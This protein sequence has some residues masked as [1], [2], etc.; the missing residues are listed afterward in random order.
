[1]PQRVPG[2][3]AP[4]FYDELRRQA[5]AGLVPWLDRTLALLPAKEGAIWRKRLDKGSPD[6]EATLLEVLTL[7]L[8]VGQGASLVELHPDFG[9]RAKGKR[10]DFLL[11]HEER[12]LVIESKYVSLQDEKTTERWHRI[13][14]LV[15]GLDKHLGPLDRSYFL[16][17]FDQPSGD[18]QYAR[19]AHELKVA[20]AGNPGQPSYRILD[21]AI[22]LRFQLE[23]TGPA[24][25]GQ[26][27]IW[28]F[29]LGNALG[30]FE[31]L[32]LGQRMHMAI[33]NKLKDY[34]RLHVPM[35][36][37]LGT[38]ETFGPGDDELL[39]T[40]FGAQT[41]TLSSGPGPVQSFNGYNLQGLFGK[42][43][44]RA[45]T[46]LSGVLVVGCWSAHRLFAAFQYK[47]GAQAGIQPWV[48]WVPNPHAEQ[49]IPAL[50][51][52]FPTLKVA[53]QGDEYEF[54]IDPGQ[55]L[56]QVLLS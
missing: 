28:S 47:L 24:R 11:R 34:G 8:A 42:P 44:D 50:F 30:T 9:S 1:V 31:E 35:V 3:A 19:L 21:Q 20:I 25:P 49:P 48:R 55:S 13:T 45:H 14:R 2:A 40:F 18:L 10:P 22:G 46:R 26:K 7:S 15:R 51:N 54:V 41:L 32:H 4:G 43:G 27:P 12:D 16:R 39:M 5:P 53:V 38:D 56:G 52:I 37:V 23:A 6:F 36:V 17:V 33:K 29:G